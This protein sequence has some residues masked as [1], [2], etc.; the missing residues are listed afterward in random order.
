MFLGPLNGT[1]TT[2]Y[3]SNNMHSRYKPTLTFAALA[4]IICLARTHPSILLFYLEFLLQ[5]ILYFSLTLTMCRGSACVR[6]LHRAQAYNL[7]K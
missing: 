7:S 2:N 5:C 1:T 6:Y 3:S 4:T